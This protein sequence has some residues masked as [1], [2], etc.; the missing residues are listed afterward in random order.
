MTLFKYKTIPFVLLWGMV[1]WLNAPLAKVQDALNAGVIA[2]VFS[3]VF[4]AIYLFPSRIKK[5]S[6]IFFVIYIP[7]AFI[8]NSF[9]WLYIESLDEVGSLFLLLLNA[10]PFFFMKFIMKLFGKIRLKI[11][12]PTGIPSEFFPVSL[13]FL[14]TVSLIV[15]FFINGD[16]GSFDFASHYDRR[17]AMMERI[18]SSDNKVL[19]YFL[20]MTTV[21]VLA[22]LAF[23][24][25]CHKKSIPALFGGFFI[26][27]FS[28]AQFWLFGT[29]ST[30]FYG[31]FMF[32]LGRFY[33]HGDFEKLPMYF[34][35][36]LVLVSLVA[37]FDRFLNEI[38]YVNAV[39][40]NRA[41]VL[42]AEVQNHYLDAVI[43]MQPG[44]I[45]DGLRLGDYRSVDF[46]IGQEYYQN[47][48]AEVNASALIS[49]LAVGGWQL[50]VTC[51]FCICVFFLFMDMLHR[52]MHQPN[53]IA[54]AAMYAICLLNQSFSVALVSSG[55]FLSLLL[56]MIFSRTALVKFSI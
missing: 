22:L 20:N 6:D 48:N 5:A 56:V 44:A 24:A 23:V 10:T 16:I 3:W 40:I 53:A 43:H 50:Y 29:K 9:V 12:L 15:C 37:V 55:V 51:V 31:V 1:F 7:I 8:G 41:F 11:T 4:I 49:S 27:I 33:S 52:R 2:V 14:L 32:C 42:T 38:P 36:T 25:G 35:W 21:G 13:S 47:P 18:A 30:L 34:L 28:I 19:A 26:I 17:L 46:F 54:I 39:I 45:F